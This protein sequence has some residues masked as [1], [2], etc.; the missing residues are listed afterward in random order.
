MAE[1]LIKNGANVSLTDNDG[2]TALH[3]AASY[4]LSSP[5]NGNYEVAKLLIQNGSDVNA[6]ALNGKAPLKIAI[7]YGKL[8]L[9][10]KYRIKNRVNL[11]FIYDLDEK[12]VAGL[13][14]ENGANIDNDISPNLLKWA[15]EN[16]KSIVQSQCIR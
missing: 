8:T 2:W 12:K 4:G 6:K 13:L 7:E 15:V 14:V 5:P 16:G 9:F 1:L 11:N 10:M 3:F